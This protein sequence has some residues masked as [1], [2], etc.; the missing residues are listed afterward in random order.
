M[1]KNKNNFMKRVTRNKVYFLKPFKCSILLVYHNSK[2]F[3][4]FS[5]ILFASNIIGL[6]IIQQVLE[7]FLIE[8]N[9]NYSINEYQKEYV[10]QFFI[11][12]M[13]KKFTHLSNSAAN[14]HSKKKLV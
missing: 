13:E 1:L 8:R 7:S 6:N 9:T 4:K 11:T 2:T 5:E 14:H 3:I 12:G 10:T